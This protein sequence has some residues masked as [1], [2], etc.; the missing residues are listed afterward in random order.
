M[1]GWIATARHGITLKKM[2]QYLNIQE[3]NKEEPK[4]KRCLLILD[5]KPVRSQV[6][7]KHS[8][9]REFQSQVSQ[10]K[11][12]L[13]VADIDILLTSRNDSVEIN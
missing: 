2:L 8:I 3:I 5:W 6:K 10:E 1:Q 12:L 11:K 13:Y 7:G 9:G 4:V